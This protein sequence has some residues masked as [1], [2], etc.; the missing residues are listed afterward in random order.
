MGTKPRNCTVERKHCTTS[1]NWHLIGIGWC[2]K[3]RW[4]DF[5]WRC[6]VFTSKSH[7]LEFV[8]TKVETITSN[9][10]SLLFR[11]WTCMTSRTFKKINVPLVAVATVY[12]FNY[13][14][15]LNFRYS[16][17]FC[18]RPK[19]IYALWSVLNGFGS[20]HWEE[21]HEDWNLTLLP[22]KRYRELLQL[23]DGFG[24]LATIVE[25]QES[26]CDSFQHINCHYN[27]LLCTGKGG[28]SIQVFERPWLGFWCTSSPMWNTALQKWQA[29][30][31]DR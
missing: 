29:V 6:I 27:A 18:S 31:R 11:I 17:S 20:G 30:L 15:Q 14:S 9:R 23:H 1:K 3:T 19:R 28:I 2:S 12:N 22:C 21:E 16:K 24:I 10:S 4:N 5:T 7:L 8:S 25:F 26:G 13:S